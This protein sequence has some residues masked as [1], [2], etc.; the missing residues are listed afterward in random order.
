MRK[1][2]GGLVLVLGITLA[3]SSNASAQSSTKPK[4]AKNDGAS[5]DFDP[6]QIS[7]VWTGLERNTT[8]KEVSPMTPWGKAQFEAHQPFNGPRSVSVGNSNDPMIKCDPLGFPRNLFHEMRAMEFI[9]TPAKTVEL[10]QYQGIWRQIWTD[11]RELPKNAGGEAVNAPDPKYYG[12]SVGKWDGDTFVVNTAGLDDDTWLDVYGDPHSDQ[13]RVEERYT[14]QTHDTMRVTVM[15]DD[16]VAYTK[17][18]MAQ[19]GEF[20]KLSHEDLPQQLCIPT[21][22]DSYLSLIAGPAAKGQK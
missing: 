20:Y 13:L 22:A 5:A 19:P 11:G 3:I 14:R 12:Y 15:V 8:G 4:D 9:Q 2:F 18:F 10:F 16:P 21:A 17:P 7:G 6:H 1:E